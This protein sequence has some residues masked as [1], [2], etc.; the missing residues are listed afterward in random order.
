MK[1]TEPRVLI[2]VQNDGLQ[3]QLFDL[4]SDYSLELTREGPGSVVELLER[5]PTLRLLII[6]E[7]SS[8]VVSLD[9]IK[10]AKAHRAD[11]AV[12]VLSGDPTIEH[13]TEAIRRGAEDFVPVPF[14]GELL[15]KEVQRILDAAELRDRVESLQGMVTDA[16]GFDRIVSHSSRM[17]PVFERARAGSRSD[18]PV[19]ITGDT[20]TGKELFAR[21]IHANSRRASKAFV[22]VNCA[23]LPRD[24]IES[25]LF[26]HR[27][28]AF[29]GALN[30]Y[31]GLFAAAH[32]GTLFLDEIG[33]LS[34]DAQA[35]L[36]RALQDGEVRPVG[37][38][39]TRHVDVRFIAATNRKLTD[40]RG[41]VLREDLFFRLSVLV[42]D[43][44]PLRERRDDVPF[45]VSHFLARLRARGLTRIEGM[46][47][48]ALDLLRKHPFPGNVRE[49]ENVLEG[50]CVTQPP[51]ATRIRVEDVR[52][53][54]DRRDPSEAS[55]SPTGLSPTAPSLKLAELESWAIKEALQRTEGNKTKAA[56]MLGISRDTLYRKL[57]EFG[58]TGAR[59]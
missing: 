4:L 53:W 55:L 59:P 50:I 28:G 33:E 32:G 46:D 19:L 17:R 7:S 26:G 16:Y 29:S 10:T 34:I 47:P 15:R 39:E 40:L 57:H 5:R 36:L 6:E 9:L 1:R 8:A 30:N 42:I 18:T 49:L 37:G 14:S 25:E 38:L 23:A 35:K 54:L 12:I 43:L 2:S 51:A 58:I 56:R 21:A 44:P 3:S 24:L 45:L 31:P 22:P 13:A 20:G 41:G 11:V 27:R 48:K 52:G